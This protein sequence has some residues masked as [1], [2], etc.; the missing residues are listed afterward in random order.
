MSEKSFVTFTTGN[1]SLS[2]WCLHSEA[3]LY[4]EKCYHHR[5]LTNI[6][7]KSQFLI[8]DEGTTEKDFKFQNSVSNIYLDNQ[9]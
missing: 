1:L 6:K 7:G 2:S 5:C 3:G 8:L 9:R 4:G